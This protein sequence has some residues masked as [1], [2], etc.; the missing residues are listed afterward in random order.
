M[1]DGKILV[2]YHTKESYGIIH[3]KQS[4]T[5]DEESQEKRELNDEGVHLGFQVQQTRH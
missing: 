3:K 4:G 5:F 2:P 1:L